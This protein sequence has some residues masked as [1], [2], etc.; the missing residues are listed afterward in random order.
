M[1]NEAH[2][3]MAFV[4]RDDVAALRAALEAGAEVEASDRWG[5]S[6]LAQAAAKGN[7]EMVRLLLERGADANRK[8]KAGNSALMAAAARGRLEVASALLDAGANPNATNT[9]GL[10]AADWAKWPESTSELLALLHGRG[11]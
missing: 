9:W 10:G 4:A 1:A 7:L 5:V 8:S 3:V 11:G 6:L 2:E